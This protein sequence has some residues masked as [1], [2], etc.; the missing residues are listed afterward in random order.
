[1]VTASPLPGSTLDPDKLPVTVELISPQD[2]DRFG[3][4]D[5]LRALANAPGVS[6]S[7]AQDNPFQ[8]NV[9]YR[10]FEASPLA[11]D[12]QGLAVYAGG[13]RLNHPFGDTVDW[14][15]IPENAI[16]SLTI[17]ST[18]PVFGLNALGGSMAMQFRNGFDFEGA[19]LMGSGGS[20]GRVEGG[21]QSGIRDGDNAFYAA[22]EVRSES[23]WRQHSPSN[24]YRLFADFDRRGPEWRVQLD[25]LGARS[26]LT[27]NGVSPVE[28]LQAARSA[29]FTYPDNTKNAFAL[30]NLE[31]TI[32]LSDSISFSGNLYLSRFDQHTLN[33]D[34][35]AVGT[36]DADPTLLCLDNGDVATG[37]NGKSI[38]AFPVELTYGQL[39]RTSTGTTGFGGSAEASLN[40]RILGQSG[41]WIAGAAWDGG[42]TRFSAD[43][44]VGGLSLERGFVGPGIIIDQSDGVVAPVSIESRNDYY[45][46]YVS[47]R[48][49]ISD[50]LSVT[51]SGRYNLAEIAL[52]DLRGAALTGHHSYTHV[53]PAAGLTYAIDPH[54]SIYGG[55]SEANRAPTPAEFSCAGENTSCTLTNFFVADPGPEA[56]RGAECGGRT[57]R[58]SGDFGN[59]HAP[60]ACGCFPQ[61]VARRHSVCGKSDYRPRVFSKYRRNQEGRCGICIRCGR[62]HLVALTRLQFHE[63]DFPVTADPEQPG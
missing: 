52:T 46:I 38:Q 37:V 60:L 32:A 49:D 62:R 10:G 33:G 59:F 35:G 45:G 20:F 44:A 36:C 39:N 19:Q 11:G 15:L 61:R 25:L 7:E 41:Q 47:A 6:F 13:V 24:L 5:L 3:T 57:A 29:V 1:M 17:E 23:G 2:I 12:A 50:A 43:T 4:P 40:T 26:D 58:V 34:A 30:A 55:Y 22:G 53:N 8:P 42:R 28:L 31:G 27:G 21:F 56:G 48:M 54:W 51:L 63:C 14:D 9:F 18:N 16:S